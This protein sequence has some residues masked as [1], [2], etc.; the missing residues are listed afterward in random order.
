MPG[1]ASVHSPVFQLH[2]GT[3]KK[4]F[5]ASLPHSKAG[6]RQEEF[7]D[8]LARADILLAANIHDAGTAAFLAQ[9]SGKCPTALFFDSAPQLEAL[10]RLDGMQ[11]DR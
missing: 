4:E 7:L 2:K 3:Q 9:Q 8:A 10:T 11:A 6:G 1:A 5:E